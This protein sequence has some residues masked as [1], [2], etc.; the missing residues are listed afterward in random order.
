MREWQVGDHIGEGYDIGVPD[1]KY[2][3]YLKDKGGTDSCSNSISKSKKLQ[4]KAWEFKENHRLYDAL[5][6]IDAAIELNPNDDENWNVKALILWSI[7]EEIDRWEIS[8]NVYDAYECFN[9][10]LEIKP[11]GKTLKSNKRS[12]L[13]DWAKVTFD[14]DDMND[15]MKRIDEYISLSDDGSDEYARGINF[16]GCIYYRKGDYKNALKCFNRALEISPDN[17]TFQEN[18]QNVLKLGEEKIN[19]D[20]EPPSEDEIKHFAELRYAFDWDYGI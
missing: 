11:S 2:M 18:R 14:M 4:D 16:K 7:F 20:W 6:T 9:R 12:F 13:Y 10:A 15:S 8:K 1:T 3:G 5:N 19:R 17:K